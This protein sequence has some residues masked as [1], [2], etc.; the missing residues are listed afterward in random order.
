MSRLAL[1]LAL[2]LVLVLGLGLVLSPTRLMRQPPLGK[3]VTTWR[4]GYPRLR[5]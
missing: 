3:V 4:T 2:V 5:R 1:A